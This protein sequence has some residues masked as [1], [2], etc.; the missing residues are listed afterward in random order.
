MFLTSVKRGGIILRS[1][2]TG[3]CCAD[4]GV[5]AMLKERRPVEMDTGFIHGIIPAVITPID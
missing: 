3:G 2:Q 1:G 4:P 5:S